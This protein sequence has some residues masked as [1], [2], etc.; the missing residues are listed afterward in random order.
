MFFLTRANN[1]PTM[2]VSDGNSSKLL[3]KPKRVA[4]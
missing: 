2:P 1:H 4:T 3:P